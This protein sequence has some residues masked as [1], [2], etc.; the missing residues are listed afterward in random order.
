MGKISI[1]RE[2][3][4]FQKSFKSDNLLT[5]LDTERFFCLR[6]VRFFEVYRQTS[7]LN[8]DAISG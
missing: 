1:D 8:E 4:L 7:L 2:Q 5:D 6:I 3:F